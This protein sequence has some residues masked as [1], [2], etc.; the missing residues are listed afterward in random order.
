M[1]ITTLMRLQHTPI[2]PP[3]RPRLGHRAFTVIEILAVG[4]ALLA[5]AGFSL[6][7]IC[8]LEM[9]HRG[10]ELSRDVLMLNGAVR[11][12]LNDGGS[13][14]SGL[15]PQQ[16][17]ERLKSPL[18]NPHP[19]AVAGI[20][21]PLIDLRLK[22]VPAEKKGARVIWNDTFHRFVLV[23][24]GPGIGSFTLDDE[25]AQTSLATLN[26]ARVFPI[27]SLATIS[28]GNG[29]SAAVNQKAPRLAPP[30]FSHG[31]GL[32]DFGALPMTLK[33]TNP[34]T[35]NDSRVLYSMNGA[36]WHE[37]DAAAGV[38]IP[39]RLSSSVRALCAPADP[40]QWSESITADQLYQTVYFHATS[41]GTFQR[42]LS[43]GA[44]QSSLG[45]DQQA[46]LVK[47]GLPRAPGG[48]RH[49]LAF[50]GEDHISALPE[51]EFR[52]GFVRYASAETQPG[53]NLIG[54][55]LALDLKI[56]ELGNQ[57]VMLPLTMPELSQIIAGSQEETS[58]VALS[59]GKLRLP[60][61]IQG[62]TFYLKVR[63]GESAGDGY[64]SATELHAT[65]GRSLMAPLY[66]TFTMVN[67][68]PL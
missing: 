39:Q 21:A 40:G 47:W 29:R 36:P 18:T 28:A 3:R 34:N 44:A 24:E 19:D 64:S 65:D 56:A 7:A 41:E 59:T 37:Y 15:D 9:M 61:P 8:Q 33:L 55:T 27:A 11:T 66:G 6:V 67:E 35:A 12:F 45:P 25:V 52:L 32:Y 42:P 46:P 54:V 5:V 63:F 58:G 49:E 68:A 30:I 1:I 16:V 13:F 53:T 60:R 43:Q 48:A 23:E 38:I 20:P 50:S 4:A 10:T 26:Q 62:Q 17:L 2:Q 57:L 22:A 31:A 14:P 51:K